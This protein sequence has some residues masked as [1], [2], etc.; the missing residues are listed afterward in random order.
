MSVVT[1]DAPVCSIEFC[2][3]HFQTIADKNDE[4]VANSE[5]ARWWP[6]RQ[7]ALP[8]KKRLV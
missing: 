2:D 3:R 4:N 6:R 8:R 5:G 7:S 1:S